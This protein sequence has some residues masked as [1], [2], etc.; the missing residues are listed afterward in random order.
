MVSD[1]VWNPS[2]SGTVRIC[3]CI[4]LFLTLQDLFHPQELQAMV[5]GNEHYDWEELE[6]VR[7]FIKRG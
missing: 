4:C 5:V 7:K 1:N 2:F 3:Q 6:K